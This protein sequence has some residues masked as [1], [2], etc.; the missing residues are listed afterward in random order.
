M[1]KRIAA[2]VLSLTFSDMIIILLKRLKIA[3]GFLIKMA[4]PK[5]KEGFFMRK[6]KLFIA[7]LVMSMVLSSTAL[8]GTWQSQDNGQWKYQN[9]DGSFATGW[10]NDGG[11]SYY[12]DANGLMLANTTTPDGY[13]A[14]DGKRDKVVSGLVVTAPSYL[15]I[16]ND[17]GSNFSIWAHYGDGKYDKDLLVNTIGD[18]TGSVYLQPGREYTLEI[19]SSGSWSVRAYPIGVSATD[20]FSGSGDYVTPMFIPSSNVYAIGGGG[21]SNFAVWGHYGTGEYDKDLLVNEIGIYSGTVMFKHKNYSFFE[22]T[23]DGDWSITP[24]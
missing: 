6:T 21:D 7:T 2:V 4:Q 1:R 9:D 15:S 23:C 13:Y 12:L 3:Y 18:Y 20:T 24:Q 14:K 10:V 8:A 11:K 16:T 22:I 19:K 17:G 5:T